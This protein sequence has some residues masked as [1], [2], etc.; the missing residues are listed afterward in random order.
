MMPSFAKP[1]L[2]PSESAIEFAALR[3]E[4]EDLLQPVDVFERAFVDELV[5]LMGEILRWR[6]IRIGVIRGYFPT[7]IENI[8]KQVLHE[9]DFMKA[10]A[11]ESEA[12]QMASDYFLDPKSKRAF[13]KMLARFGLG[14]DAIETEAFRLSG[15]DLD[16]VDRMLAAATRRRDKVLRFI[17]RY[18][19]GNSRGS[20]RCEEVR[21]CQ[22]Y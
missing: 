18:R 3:S 2:L 12:A 21:Y 10:L 15:V 1:C 16:R 14:A 11:I 13:L 8:Y 19:L 17:G 22:K 20:P 9:P 6:R 7:A 4:L 5:A